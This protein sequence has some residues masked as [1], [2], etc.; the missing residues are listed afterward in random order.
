[1]DPRAARTP[2]VPAGRMVSPATG[3]EGAITG[4][5]AAEMAQKR[6]G[7]PTRVVSTTFTLTTT[8]QQFIANNP[9]RVFLT[10]INRGVVNA[11][12]DIELS[13]TFA[14]GIP[15]GA[16]GGFLTM[17]VEEDG[18]SVGWSLYGACESGTCV[19]RVLEV[20]RV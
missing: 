7:G 16:A 2:Y 18:E 3:A 11:A 20:M 1:M 17:D 9:K 13:S 10:V 8:W 15:L 5:T 12:A 19:V 6:F 4:A 14:N